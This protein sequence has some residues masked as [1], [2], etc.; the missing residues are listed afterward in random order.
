MK[1]VVMS[2]GQCFHDHMRIA[3]LV[4]SVGSDI[5]KVDFANIALKKLKENFSLYSL[6]LVNR[7]FDADN[8]DGIDFIKILKNTEIVKDI[9][10]M[11]ISNYKN[12]QEEAV[13]YGAISGFG[14]DE[15]HL[16]ETK[17]KLEKI[18]KS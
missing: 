6:V 10:V 9:P 17:E 18:L 14:K 12:F 4:Q 5:E 7:K 15:L 2:V 8:L 1:K 11:L 3:Q 13:K 16:K